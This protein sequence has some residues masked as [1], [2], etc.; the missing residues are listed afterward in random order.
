MFQK[1]IKQANQRMRSAIPLM[2]KLNIP[3]TPENYG[4]WYEYASNSTP[5]L[6]QIVDKAIRRFGSLPSFV[7]S[8][9]YREFLLP[10]E[11]KKAK[12]HNQTLTTLSSTLGSDTQ[13]ALTQ[14]TAFSTKLTQ[15]S[16]ELKQEPD[17][18]QLEQLTVMLEQ[19]ALETNTVIK[20]YSQHLLEVQK[21]LATLKV[22]LSKSSGKKSDETDLLTSLANVKGFERYLFAFNQKAEDD[23]SLLLID[24][25]DLAGINKEYGEKA[26][27]ALIRYVGKLLQAKLPPHCVLARIEGGRFAALLK[28]TE[29]SDATS[30]ANQLQDHVASQKIR[31]KNT[32]TL[33]RQ[34]TVTIGV[35]TVVGSESPKQLIERAQKSLNKSKRCR[36][37]T[38]SHYE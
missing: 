14:L 33:L 26:G 16:A 19:S 24:I 1:G 34:V 17:N 37:N 29:L 15:V 20:Q 32:Q 3:P 23:L 12:S 18:G 8:D 22:A 10:V 31:Y 13:T 2:L 21:E 7:S 11:A 25:D 28:E 6:N 9:L 27:A 5:K 4:I 30:L 35:V 36:K 38:V